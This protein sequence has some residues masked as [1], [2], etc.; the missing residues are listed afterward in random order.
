MNIFR[1]TDLKINFRTINTIG[2]LLTH[3]NPNPDVY[4]LSGAYKITWPDCNE[5]YVGK[6]GRKFSARYKEHKT[7][8]RNNNHAYSLAKHL[9][10]TAHSFGPMNEIMQILQC[11]K[12]GPHLNTIERFHIHVESKANNHLNDDHTTFQNAIFDVLLKNHYP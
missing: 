7:A 5:A 12:K 8:F 3:K 10:D 11:H 1:R 9:N 2:N 6:T 4:T